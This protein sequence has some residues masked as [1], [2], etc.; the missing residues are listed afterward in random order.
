M[1]YYMSADNA[2]HRLKVQIIL[3]I[4]VFNFDLTLD[5]TFIHQ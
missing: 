2:I 3:I 5:Y 1:A 4:P